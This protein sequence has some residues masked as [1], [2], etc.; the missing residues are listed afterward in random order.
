MTLATGR[1]S[2]QA[3]DELAQEGDDARGEETAVVHI[4][5]FEIG[6]E[7]GLQR[8]TYPILDKDITTEIPAFGPPTME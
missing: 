6:W 7:N 3:T 2:D 1:G 8:V 5:A 4:G